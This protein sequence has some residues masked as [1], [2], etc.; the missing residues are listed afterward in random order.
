MWSDQLLQK[1]SSNACTIG[2]HC[3]NRMIR[4]SDDSET[5]MSFCYSI[6]KK[7]S[8][9]TTCICDGPMFAFSPPL[10]PYASLLVT[11]LCKEQMYNQWL[12][13]KDLIYN[14]AGGKDTAS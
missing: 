12:L 10:T 3:R 11:F 14:S 4:K 1:L 6:N 5:K 13:K 8:K 9:Q 7:K 2:K